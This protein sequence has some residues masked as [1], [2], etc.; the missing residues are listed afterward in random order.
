MTINQILTNRYNDLKKLCKSNT[1]MQ[2]QFSSGLKDIE[3]I[4]LLNTLCIRWINKYQNTE[5]EPEIF[6]QLKTE[7]LGERN[8]Q[9]KEKPNQFRFFPLKLDRKS[10]FSNNNDE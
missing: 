2:V 10:K 8:F 4:D 6:N 3:D 5:L 7:F 9:T 1:I